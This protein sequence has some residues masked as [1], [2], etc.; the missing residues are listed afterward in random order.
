MSLQVPLP[1]THANQVTQWSSFEVYTWITKHNDK[2]GLSQDDLDSIEESPLTGKQLMGKDDEQ[3]SQE[4]AISIHAARKIVKKASSTQKKATKR[5][6]EPI[7]PIL[8]NGNNNNNNNGYDKNKQVVFE[9]KTNDKA[10]NNPSLDN[11]PEDD[12]YYDTH[13]QRVQSPVMTSFTP[14]Q[15]SPNGPYSSY[16]QSPHASQYH[17]QYQQSLQTK[18]TLT[19]KND[20][21]MARLSHPKWWM[22]GHFS[23][24]PNKIGCKDSISIEITGDLDTPLVGLMSFTLTLDPRFA[25]INNNNKGTEYAFSPYVGHN[26]TNVMPP[27]IP[28]WM[29]GPGGLPY[30]PPSVTQ[31]YQLQQQYITKLNELEKEKVEKKEE[32]ER[33]KKRKE[34]RRRMKQQA[35]QH[36]LAI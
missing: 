1:L 8:T 6:S 12:M 22:D 31:L 27:H 5:K 23:H 21:F 36:R 15:Y 25:S 28:S 20:T 14:K 7:I 10:S 9:T 11:I 24:I 2:F 33:K 18:L 19:I 17:K 34:E 35:T 3:L 13:K 29:I 32:I 4:W 30:I 26:G 16:F